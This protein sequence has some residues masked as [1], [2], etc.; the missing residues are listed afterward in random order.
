MEKQFCVYLLAN[1]KL[2]ERM[3]NKAHQC[4]E[5]GMEGFIR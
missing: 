2:E 5:S 1:K 3:K 4:Y